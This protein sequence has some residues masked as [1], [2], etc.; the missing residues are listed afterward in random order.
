VVEEKAGQIQV[1]E[2]AVPEAD[3]ARKEV[4]TYDEDDNNGEDGMWFSYVLF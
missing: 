3:S 2:S 1:L 4:E